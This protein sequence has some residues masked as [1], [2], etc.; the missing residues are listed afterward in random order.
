[1]SKP[2]KDQNLVEI[3]DEVLRKLLTDSEMRMLKNRWKII[4]LLRSGM[5]VRAVSEQARVG[6]D[7]VIRVSKI[8]S[9][10][11]LKKEEVPLS[12]RIATPW[13]FGKGK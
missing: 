4:Q 11:G 12:R 1:M 3:P 7:T 2:L 9:K 8:M 6:T 13:V 5:T 10:Q